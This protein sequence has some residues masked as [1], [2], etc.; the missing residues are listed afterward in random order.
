MLTMYRVYAKVIGCCKSSVGST[1]NFSSHKEQSFS[2]AVIVS[3]I[4][5]ENT[6][7]HFQSVS[8]HTTKDRSKLPKAYLAVYVHRQF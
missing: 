1:I 7:E 2:G 3:S 8:D 4:N 5:F 6:S